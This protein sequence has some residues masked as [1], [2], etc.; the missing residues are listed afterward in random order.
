MGAAVARLLLT[1][2]DRPSVLVLSDRDP[3]AL[4]AVVESLAGTTS[5][6]PEEHDTVVTGVVCDVSRESSVK[7]LF[8]EAGRRGPLTRVIHA[9]G[10]LGSGA[11]V[12]DTPVDDF[13]RVFAVNARGTFLVVRE[14][15]GT[16]LAQDGATDST[17]PG[18]D[19]AERA[20]RAD[21]ADHADR[22]DRA[23][24]AVTVI[25]SN[26]AGV[27]RHGMGVY[28]ASKAAASSLTRSLGLEVAGTGIRCNVVN[29]GSTDTAMQR[30]YWGDDPGAG[31]RRVLAG[32][33]STARL[34]IPLGRIASPADVAEVVVFLSSPQA[35]HVILQEI[36]VDGGATLHA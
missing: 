7:D 21:H 33:L 30:D 24:R 22:A 35:R 18:S 12:T 15:A 31:R 25:A 28:A 10:V 23:D 19:P 27:P 9:A 16:M 34:G 1:R 11:T 20:D 36:Y 4:A 13:D 5:P 26:A 29:P 2:P 3:A 17:A 14:A 6:G 8:C 32:D